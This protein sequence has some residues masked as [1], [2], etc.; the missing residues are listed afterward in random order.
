MPS[1]DASR[2]VT[3]ARPCE[4]SM[5]ADTSGLW[6]LTASASCR[7]D[8]RVR[9]HAQ[10][11][12]VAAHDA[13]LLDDEGVGA[14]L[15][16]NGAALTEAFSPWMSDT[17]AMIDVTATMLP[18]TVMSDR[19]LA[20]QMALSAM[21]AAS[22]YLFTAGLS[23]GWLHP[24]RIAVSHAA[25]VVVRAGDDLIARFHARQHLEVAVAR[26]ADLDRHELRASVADDENAFG[27]LARLSRLQLR[28]RR[29]RAAPGVRVLGAGLL[30]DAALCVVDELAHG[31]GRNR[32]G[33]DILASGCRD[34]GR[35]REPRADVRHVLVEHD[36]HFEVGRLLIGRRLTGRLN[37]AVADFRH[38][39][40]EGP[41]GNRVDRDFRDL[42]ELDV[43]NVGFVDLDFGLDDRHVGDRQQHRAGVVHRADDGRLPLLDV[44][45]RDDAGDR[46]FDPHF[47]EIELRAGELRAI[48]PEPHLLRAH[49]L[50]ALGKRRLRE[51]DVVL[52]SFERFARGELLLPQLLLALE[53]LLRDRQL[54]ASG[55]DRLPRL[56]EPRLAACSAAWPLSTRVRSV[57]GSICMRNWPSFTRSPS[58]TARSTTRPDVS[59]L[60]LTNRFGWI[61]P[62][63]ETTASRSRARMDSTV[64]IGA[65]ERRD[66]QAYPP[67]DAMTI[68]ASTAMMIFL[69]RD[70][71]MPPRRACVNASA[72]AP[73]TYAPN[74]HRA[75]D[76]VRVRYRM[77]SPIAMSTTH[78][79]TNMSTAPTRRAGNVDSPK[80]GITMLRLVAPPSDSR[81]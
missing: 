1:I 58:L 14:R 33:H 44:P 12:F 32:H 20:A 49:L 15:V 67:A 57:R 48:L 22:R 41:V 79:T 31:D 70:N 59:A 34:L 42:P 71:Y 36:D 39:P 61:L 19:S 24:D 21:P 8:A 51:A 16:E 4:L 54:H 2:Y 26:D 13:E 3:R 53:I 72:A 17:T 35:A 28:R 64:T 37:R 74:S 73:L 69:V 78:H 40:L 55:F 27:L 46:R 66:H 23:A 52:R 38:V 80:A 56:F 65:V 7:R 29:R 63:A 18:S 25:H 68:R 5:T 76:S 9:L 81:A 77:L 6:R 60:M 43:R 45:A 62:E 11:L 30:H 10:P 47:A 50:L 75:T